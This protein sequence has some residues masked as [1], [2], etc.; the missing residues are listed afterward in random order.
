[1][2]KALLYVAALFIFA[3]CSDD[4]YLNIDA[5]L[6]TSISAVQQ[7][8]NTISFAI[9]SNEDWIITTDGQQWYTF[10]ALEGHGSAT[11][12]IEVEENHSIKPRSA[13]FSITSESFSEE[14]P[15]AQLGA[16]A[17]A[18]PGEL[19][20]EEIYYTKTLDKTTGKVA[21][22]SQDQ[23]IKITN[24][25]S[26]V[27]YADRLAFIGS[28]ILSHNGTPTTYNPDVRDKQSPVNMVFVVPG[29]GDDYP[30]EA[31]SSI[32]IAA[33]AQKFEIGSNVVDLT[34]ADFEW[35]DNSTVTTVVDTDNPSVPNLEIWFTYSA[36]ITTL[37]QQG[38][39]SYA[40][41]YIPESVTAEDYL[42][43]YKWT[44]T[45]IQDYSKYGLG[46]KESEI[47]DA[48]LI[49]N[50]WIIDA[51]NISHPNDFT[52]LPFHQSLDAGYTYCGTKNTVADR[53]S[54]S[55]IRKR[56]AS[57]ALVDTN[58]STNDFNHSSEP[59]L[60]K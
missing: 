12:S 6:A 39:R 26:H 3:A 48:Y 4:P 54:K 19:L 28:Y 25:T 29:D 43:N 51:V 9:S 53:S 41:A 50:S 32:I 8:G 23:Y 55:V 2:K 34:S 36:S 10:S 60:L 5:E 11:V 59:S 16:T 38:Y 24:T 15:L 30:I 27:V 13:R 22:L 37:H 42:A 31:N 7:N 47:K 20:I 56:N 52:D 49:P 33:G 17:Q 46:I 21:S 57:G 35:Y 1:M 45:K 40:I 14:F 58:N 18:E 44:G